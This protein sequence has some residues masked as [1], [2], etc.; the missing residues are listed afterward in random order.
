[1]TPKINKF[2]ELVLY[3]PFL[4][5]QGIHKLLQDL[6]DDFG[7]WFQKIFK[8]SQGFWRVLKRVLRG[9]TGIERDSDSFHII[10]N[11]FWGFEWFS[12]VFSQFVTFL[13][14]LQQIIGWSICNISRQGRVTFL[15]N[16]VY[17]C[18][19]V[20]IID[21]SQSIPRLCVIQI[22]PVPSLSRATLKKSPIQFARP[23][24]GSSFPSPRT[25]GY[26][27]TWRPLPRDITSHEGPTPGI[28]LYTKALRIG[29]LRILLGVA[30]FRT[31][32]ARGGQF[33]QIFRL[34]SCLGLWG[35]GVHTILASD[36]EGI[37][38]PWGH[39]TYKRIPGC[40]EH[41]NIWWPEPRGH[42]SLMQWKKEMSPWLPGRVMVHG[43]IE[44]HIKKIKIYIQLR[45]MS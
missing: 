45:L 35:R 1:M 10:S 19:Y 20:F 12:Y 37:T 2:N 29:F 11:N 27:L 30:I 17:V 34:E 13:G 43:R 26:H 8:V 41:H 28:S 38:T 14:N 22:G 24:G 23:Q 25:Q 36:P 33:W 32:F 3:C 31:I 42:H 16:L 39:H 21:I 7:Y 6:T 40:W 44:W 9:F 5:F 15:V 4:Y 18:M